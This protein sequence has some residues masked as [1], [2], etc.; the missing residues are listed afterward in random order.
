MKPRY[1]LAAFSA[2]VL[3]SLSFALGQNK[4]EVKSTNMPKG[5][6]GD[7][8]TEL[9]DV[10][11]KILD[12]ARA[13]PAEEYS[14][15][16]M[17]DVRSVSEVYMHIGGANYLLPTFVGIKAPMEMKP[18]ME[19]TVTDKT[20]VI[21]FLKQSFDHIRAAVMNTSDA[22]LDKPAKFFGQETTVRG[23]FFKAANHMHEHLGQSIAY[24]RMNKVVPPWTAAEQAQA[25]KDSKK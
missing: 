16:P 7:F 25:K 2:I 18:D 20:K 6:R 15:R 4:S 23:I 5:F 24:A 11:Q 12:L 19:K 10:E 1:F 13:M 14:W 21:E 22:D 8:L 17:E 9:N 3:F